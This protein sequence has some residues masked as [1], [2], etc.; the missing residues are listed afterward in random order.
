MSVIE[1]IKSRVSNPLFEDADISDETISTLLDSAVCTPVHYNTEPWRFLVL[2]GEARVRFGD[3]LA[4]RAASKMDDPTE[5]LNVKKLTRIRNKPLRA[6]VVIVAG[7]AKSDNPKALMVEDI[8]SVNCACHN[9]LLASDELGLAAMW[10]TGSITYAED[11]A[12]FL[13]FESGTKLVA[14]IYLGKPARTS[15]TK[16]RKSSYYFTRWMEK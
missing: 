12:S 2:K 13:G 9:I 8:A 11:V 14:F 6:P 5:D 16:T 4:E 7:A 15:I 10:R 3:F 1:K